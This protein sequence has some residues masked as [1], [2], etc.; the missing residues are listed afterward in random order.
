MEWTLALGQRL[1]IAIGSLPLDHRSSR[2]R[3]SSHPD[4]VGT[5]LLFVFGHVSGAISDLPTGRSILSV[6]SI[7]SLFLKTFLGKSDL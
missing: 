4:G 2:L 1:L 6:P 7:M 3:R 5:Q